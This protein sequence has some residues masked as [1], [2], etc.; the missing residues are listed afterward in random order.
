MKLAEVGAS[1]GFFMTSASLAC[2]RS[3]NIVAALLTGQK[4]S[5]GE[6]VAS[7]QLITSDWSTPPR[8]DGSLPEAAFNDETTRYDDALS[9][10]GLVQAL[11][12]GSAASAAT[13]VRAAARRTPSRA[14]NNESNR[15]EVC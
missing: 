1:V 7:A 2:P 3:G 6:P 14:R 5:P 11:L 13:I 4:A 10:C 8:C 9:S 12:I 15:V